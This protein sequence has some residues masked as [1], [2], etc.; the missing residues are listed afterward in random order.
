MDRDQQMMAAAAQLDVAL[1]PD[2][3]KAL[4]VR[5]ADVDLCALY[6]KAKP[7]L[8][9][10]LPVIEMF[11]WGGAVAKAI[12]LVMALADQVCGA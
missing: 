7:I 11:P 8:N 12:R 3:N 9:G 10:I 2:V 1:G 6:K 4:A 5:P